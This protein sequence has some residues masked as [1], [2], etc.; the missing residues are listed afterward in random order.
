MRRV[1]SEDD[2]D[3]GLVSGPDRE[4]IDV[5]DPSTERQ[6][7][8]GQDSR[9]ADVVPPHEKGEPDLELDPAEHDPPETFD[10]DHLHV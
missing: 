9:F 3:L 6:V 10:H 5:G 1:R 7:K 4:V 2:I 8:R